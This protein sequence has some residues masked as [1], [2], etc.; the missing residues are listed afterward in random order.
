MLGLFSFREMTVGN[1]INFW[2]EFLGTLGLV[3]DHVA[4]HPDR[5]MEWT[6]FYRGRVAIVADPECI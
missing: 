3:P 5:L 6:P 1:A 4:I 2:L